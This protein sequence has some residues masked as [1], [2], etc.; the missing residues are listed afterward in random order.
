MYTAGT[1]TN[2]CRNSGSSHASPGLMCAGVPC[3][4]AGSAARQT[5]DVSRAWASAW[6]HH[7]QTACA[8]AASAWHLPQHYAGSNRGRVRLQ[9]VSKPLPAHASSTSLHQ[10]TSPLTRV[11]MVA[12]VSACPSGVASPK[13]ATLAVR[14]K[15]PACIHAS[16]VAVPWSSLPRC[17]C[18]LLA[19]DAAVSSTLP[20]LR[21]PC[22]RSQTSRNKQT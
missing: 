20:A 1:L 21:S 7:R 5:K 22:L 15:Q 6:Q 18:A 17:C 19:I 12:C 11:I 8:D 3:E 9:H 4:H 13:S 16:A 2:R 10:I 14:G